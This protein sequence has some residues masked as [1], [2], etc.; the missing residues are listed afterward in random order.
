MWIK[1][2]FR[3][4]LW[5]WKRLQL[6]CD[7][8]VSHV[9]Y[10]IWISYF[11]IYFIRLSWFEALVLE[12]IFETWFVMIYFYFEKWK[13]LFEIWDITSWNQTPGLSDLDK[14]LSSIQWL[15]VII[16]HIS[17]RYDQCIWHISLVCI[18][19]IWSILHLEAYK[20]FSFLFIYI[21]WPNSCLITCQKNTGVRLVKP[22]RYIWC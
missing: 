18:I 9:Y 16:A 14:H 6:N 11:L 21:L 13:I 3:L 1:F 19:Y 4:Y 15:F 20:T 12:T 5:Q 2:F 22:N 17:T 7:A 8:C 10:V